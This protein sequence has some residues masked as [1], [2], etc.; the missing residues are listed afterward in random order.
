MLFNK[1]FDIFYELMC[2]NVVFSIILCLLV[3]FFVIKKLY[4]WDIV[5]L[6]FFCIECFWILYLVGKYFEEGLKIFLNSFEV[7]KFCN[8]LFYWI[9]LM[10]FLSLLMFLN[11]VFVLEC[12]W[13][14]FYFL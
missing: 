14:C 8:M 9:R 2:L 7:V 3:V 4:F 10:V 6:I 11:G 13:M 12:F 1:Y 5:V